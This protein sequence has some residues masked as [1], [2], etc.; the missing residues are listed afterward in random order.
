MG[1]ACTHCGDVNA[2]TIEKCEE[3][4]T[5]H[6]AKSPVRVEPQ[7]V[8][9]GVM[10]LSTLL[11]GVLAGYAIAIWN[12]RLL[13]RLGIFTTLLYGLMGIGGWLVTIIIIANFTPP[14]SGEPGYGIPVALALSFLLV[15]ISY[16]RDTLAVNQWIWTHPGRKLVLNIGG[17][18]AGLSFTSFSG[19][20]GELFGTAPTKQPLLSVPILPVIVVA[21]SA[22]IGVGTLLLGNYFAPK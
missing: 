10:W 9:A 15:S 4:G 7:P 2:G 17:S 6:S 8:S 13:R 16:N 12:G 11:G 18:N 5:A 14:D 19:A 21:I 3:C 22:A 1:W 20:Q